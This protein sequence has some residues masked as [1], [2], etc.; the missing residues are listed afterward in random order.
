MSKPTENQQQRMD[1]PPGSI[2]VTKQ[3]KKT[4]PT[5]HKH[6]RLG[7]GAEP[8]PAAGDDTPFQ[9]ADFHGTPGRPSY[10][11]Y[12][13]S[14]RNKKKRGLTRHDKGGMIGSDRFSETDH[15][16][17]LNAYTS[18]AYKSMNTCLRGECTGTEKE[19]A[20]SR[21][22]ISALMDLINIQDPTSGQTNAYRGIRGVR[23]DLAPGDEFHDPGFSSTSSDPDFASSWISGWGTTVH[24]KIPAG[25]QVLDVSSLGGPQ[26]ESEIIL[27]PGSK[28]RVLK[29]EVPDP[30]LP[31]TRVTVELING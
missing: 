30:S 22:R 15:E 1:W 28:F 31:A 26:G 21:E 4:A 2:T 9:D 8:V 16:K 18:S 3:A 13:P 25:S 14:G 12:H 10:R 6:A 24:I 20:Q 23:L 17:S 7:E 5:K 27:P 19:I 29:V 11:R